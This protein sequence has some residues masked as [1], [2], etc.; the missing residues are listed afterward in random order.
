MTA[1]AAVEQVLY[2]TQGEQALGD[3]P[4]QVISTILGSCVSVCL[5]DPR[6]KMGG[7]NHIILP[8]SAAGLERFGACAMERLINAL[9]KQGA[10]RDTMEAKVFGGAAIV[11]GLS[12]IGQRNVEFALG[13]LSAEGIR[14]T[15]QSVGGTSARQVRFWPHGGLA[16]QR[17]V[18]DANVDKIAVAP[19]KPANGVELF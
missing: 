12:N 14:C 1:G 9:L 15:G 17:L 6:L 3:R 5:W 8:A 19:V 13:Y 2:I 10:R 16:R 18:A 4:E 11:E 7:M